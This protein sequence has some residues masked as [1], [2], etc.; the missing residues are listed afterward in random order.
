MVQKAPPIKAPKIVPQKIVPVKINEF[1]S[2]KRF[3]KK[4]KKIRNCVPKNYPW[5][6]CKQ[7]LSGAGFRP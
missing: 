1:I 6:L 2:L 4:K 3:K 5:M 7:Y